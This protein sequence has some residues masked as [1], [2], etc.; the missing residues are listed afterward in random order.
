M[1][2]MTVFLGNIGGGAGTARGVNQHV[3]GS[4]VVN[5]GGDVHGGGEKLINIFF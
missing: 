3:S 4:H 5:A 1:A 2:I